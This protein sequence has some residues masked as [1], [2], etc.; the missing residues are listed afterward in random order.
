MEDNY[1]EAGLHLKTS[2]L[3]ESSKNITMHLTKTWAT[4]LGN[5]LKQAKC[6]WV[7]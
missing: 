3:A 1:R 2:F 5:I 7:L 4:L 6:F